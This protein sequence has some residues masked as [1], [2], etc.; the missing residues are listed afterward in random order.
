MAFE[1]NTAQAVHV[2]LDL[3]ARAAWDN[4]RDPSPATA[5]RARTLCASLGIDYL[6]LVVA[7]QKRNEE[8]VGAPVDVRVAMEEAARALSRAA[9]R[10]RA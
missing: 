8:L 6:A 2:D 1:D 5:C 10:L 7:C 3:V 4:V 9:D